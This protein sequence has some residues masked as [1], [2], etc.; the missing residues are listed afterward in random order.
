MNHLLPVPRQFC[1]KESLY[2]NY[3]SFLSPG[4]EER[5]FNSKKLVVWK[6][7][8]QNSNA[9]LFLWSVVRYHLT[10]LASLILWRIQWD[11]GVLRSLKKAS[12]SFSQTQSLQILFLLV[13]G[14]TTDLALQ[15]FTIGWFFFFF[16]HKEVVAN[17]R[18]VP[19]KR[20]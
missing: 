9:L 14:V 20:E 12:V 18:S 3:F 4:S 13:S 15:V 7:D 16:F 6:S 17:W 8:C 2:M 19:I 11:V 10:Y 1:W 5:P